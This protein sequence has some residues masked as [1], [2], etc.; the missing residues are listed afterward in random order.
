[1]TGAVSE[2][3]GNLKSLHRD[4]PPLLTT[5]ADWKIHQRPDIVISAMTG[6]YTQIT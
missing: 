3:G 2:I 6:L 5:A 1:M 4:L